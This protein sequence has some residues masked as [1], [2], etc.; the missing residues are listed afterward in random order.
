MRMCF[1]PGQKLLENKLAV[2]ILFD[3]QKCTKKDKKKD[4]QSNFH[5]YQILSTH[6]HRYGFIFCTLTIGH[7]AVTSIFRFIMWLMILYAFEPC[8]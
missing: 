4:F 5:I 1:C 2:T 3:T 8:C 6:L 7:W